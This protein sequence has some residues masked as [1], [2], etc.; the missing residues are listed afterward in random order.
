MKS[1]GAV[2]VFLYVIILFVLSGPLAGILFYPQ[3]N[4]LQRISSVYSEHRNIQ[5]WIY[6]VV[7]LVAQGALL[8][9]PV[10]TATRRPVTRRTIVP[11][12]MATSLAMALLISGVALA[13]HELF[14]IKNLLFDNNWIALSIFLLVWVVWA[15][16]FARWSG[17]MG[18]Q[19]F[20]ER[21]CR[22]MFRGSILELLVAVPSHV[23]VRQR[24]DC[25]AGIETGLGISLGLA[26]MLFSFGPGVFIL[27][28]ERFRHLRKGHV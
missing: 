19:G 14:K 10:E 13:A 8:S 4:F 9:V 11:L 2:V 24:D 23:L 21:Q 20:V 15:M 5:V 3:D 26:V 25:C 28:S 18:S 12:V 1:W 6:L 7:A 22:W 16:V 27:F 17:R